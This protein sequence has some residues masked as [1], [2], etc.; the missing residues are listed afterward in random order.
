[1]PQG[2]IVP[3]CLVAYIEREFR[4]ELQLESEPP[5][6]LDRRIESIVAPFGTPEVHELGHLQTA[7]AQLRDSGER[8]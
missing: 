5:S 6:V 3:V 4:W 8:D 2:L 7:F 1:M